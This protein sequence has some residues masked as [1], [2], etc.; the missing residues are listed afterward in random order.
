MITRDIL[1]AWGACY[2]DAEIAGLV[3]EA[4]LTPLQVLDLE[5][6]AIDRLW[7]VLHEDVIPARDLRLLACRWA[8]GALDAERA[9]GREPDPRSWAAVETAE[10]YAVGEAT[11]EQLAAARAA[12]RAAAWAARAAVRYAVSDAAWDAAWAV[13]DAS[14][15]WAAT[16]L[17]DARA[18]I[19]ALEAGK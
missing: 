19:A 9:A 6:P 5:I 18:V 14:D 8:R 15:A 2:T 11:V 13:R 12:A 1:R 3:P 10:R 16:Q 17:N 7:V 4:G